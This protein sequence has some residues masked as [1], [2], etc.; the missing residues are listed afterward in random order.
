MGLLPERAR[1][2][3]PGCRKTSLFVLVN[4]VLHCIGDP[5][6]P[7]EGCGKKLSPSRRL[8]AK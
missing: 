1:F 7:R 6:V 4:D 5:K 8:K 2:Y 3:C